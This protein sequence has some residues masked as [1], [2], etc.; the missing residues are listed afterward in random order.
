M[1]R[2]GPVGTASQPPGTTPQQPNTTILSAIWNA[3]QN[4]I[5]QIFN[6]KTPIAYGGT[7]AETV[8]EARTNLGVQP[9]TLWIAYTPTFTGV[10][11]VSGLKCRSRRNG[12]CLEV[13]ASWQ[14]GTV[15]S[16]PFSMTLGFNGANGGINCDS[17]WDTY[18][19]FLGSA[20]WNVSG[21]FNLSIIGFGSSN[22]VNI[23]IASDGRN[24]L[25]PVI[26]TALG[27]GTVINTRFAVPIQ[28]WNT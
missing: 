28:G 9:A 22:L 27:T 4:D 23:G 18:R 8:E 17:Y 21:A 12:P 14:N 5:Y 15:S 7:N 26:G 20:A 10:G 2:S 19:P 6:T 25:T 3:V 11:T 13:E 1:P 16:D 24:G